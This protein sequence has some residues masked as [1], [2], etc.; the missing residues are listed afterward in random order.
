M[1]AR[2]GELLE[3][4]V[5]TKAKFL[6]A[7]LIELL[8]RIGV[9]PSGAL[10]AIFFHIFF[11]DS[12]Y[13]LRLKGGTA[14]SLTWAALLVGSSF[15]WRLNQFFFLFSPFLKLL[16]ISLKFTKSTLMILLK[17]PINIYIISSVM[18][19]FWLVLTY[20]LL[21][22]RRIDDV[23]IKTF[24]ILYYIKQ[25]DSKLPCV[26][27]VIDHRGRQNVVRTSV[28]H[29]AT[30]RVPLFCSY[31]ILTS[32]GIYYWTDAR[33]LGIYLLNVAS[34]TKLLCQIMSCLQLPTLKTQ[35]YLYNMHNMFWLSRQMYIHCAKSKW[36][37]MR[38]TSWKEWFIS[39]KI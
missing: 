19:A 21:E 34:D 30:S 16:K 4:L 36:M 31:H 24:L 7:S 6:T 32:S 20:N 35:V 25:I 22:D 18:H 37:L 3:W 28:T 29:S 39:R 2:C 1:L 5:R 10:T 8:R 13:G 12:R 26:C 17:I 33:Q 15:L 11:L 38:Y 14:G 27:S 9:T 23:I